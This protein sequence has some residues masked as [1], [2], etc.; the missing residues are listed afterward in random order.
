MARRPR[1][2]DNAF[3]AFARF[4]AR[5]R[6]RK[7]DFW[8]GVFESPLGPLVQVVI[9]AAFVALGLFLL[10]NTLEAL[11][12]GVIHGRRS[13]RTYLSE[14][15]A[16]FW[17]QFGWNFA[18]GAL[19]IGLVVFGLWNRFGTGRGKQD[20][21]QRRRRARKKSTDSEYTEQGEAYLV[22]STVAHS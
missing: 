2:K 15:P 8:D 19:P 14:A 1:K 4:D 6:K 20:A 11:S 3:E 13:S 5:W 21:A 7:E 22:L 16:F 10:S 17:L 18:L 12:S 9:G